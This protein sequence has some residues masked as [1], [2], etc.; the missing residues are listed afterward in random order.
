[1]PTR[2]TVICYTLNDGMS[3]CDLFF[4]SVVVSVIAELFKIFASHQQQFIG[5]STSTAHTLNQTQPKSPPLAVP[6]TD[7]LEPPS[8]E[9]LGRFTMLRYEELPGC[10]ETQHAVQC[11]TEETRGISFN[12]A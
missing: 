4:H 8:A 3:V 12:D 9:L 11:A 5:S 10:A 1:V 7:L 6:R 2:S